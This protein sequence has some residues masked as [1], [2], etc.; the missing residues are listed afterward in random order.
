[1]TLYFL[2]V[3]NGCK[4]G[5]LKALYRGVIGVA[6]IRITEYYRLHKGYKNHP[7]RV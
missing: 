6:W 5:I 3:E 4:D 2:L 7:V 1:M